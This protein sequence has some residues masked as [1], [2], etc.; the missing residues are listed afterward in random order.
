[1]G[2][3]AVVLLVGGITLVLLRGKRVPAP[4][5]VETSAAPADLHVVD[6]KQLYESYC[7]QCHG[8]RGTGDGPA[9]R[10]LYP[11]PRNFPEAK[12][13]VV[14]TVNHMP[15]D[16]DLLR[17]ITRGMPGSAMFSFAHLSESERHAL[18]GYV[19]QLAR[20]GLLEQFRAKLGEKADVAELE[21][22]IDQMLQ[23]GEACAVP[24]DLPASS[25]ESVAR[26]HKLY[27]SEACLDCHGETGKGDGV[28]DQRDAAGMP[29]RP[30]DFTRG[31]FKG[32]HEPAQLYARI[33]L[34]MSG[35]P[36]P[37]SPKLQ[38]AQVGD[39]INYILSL[40][41]PAARARVEHR[42]TRLLAKR[43][44]GTLPTDSA[45][46][47]WQVTVPAPILVSPL[48]WREYTEPNLHVAALHNGQTL[49]L[50][51]TWQDK[52]RDDR[53]VRPQDFEDMAAVQLY[54]GGREP[55]LGMGLA[56][57]AV[58][59]WLWRASWQA[60]A[61]KVADVDTTY[62]N[63]A[64]DLYPFERAGGGPRPHATE[65]Q[66]K[67][68]LTARAAGNLLSDPSRTFSGSSLQAKGFGTL[69]MRPAISQVVSASGSWKE[70]SWTVVLR[71]PLEVTSE[72][73]ISLAPGDALSIAFALWD[74]TARD[75]NGQ[76]LISIWHDLQ[77]E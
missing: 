24:A 32:G 21:Q 10:Y 22:D 36:M 26:G 74:G 14:T 40:S 11:R 1:L 30:R 44:S 69:T 43:T 52:T 59:T 53:P 64:V 45:D 20:T 37:E 77:L 63:M 58:D 76:K 39:L 3:L 49:A 42:R 25:A 57:K 28:K 5:P 31:F 41:D 35:T 2:S 18:V 7:A 65:R 4:Q 70:G 55:F 71:R 72:A 9:A 34:G 51:L 6:G 61:D 68:Y 46:D 27:R 16:Q 60:G 56:D 67:E 47:A 33:V 38:P 13:R 17:V 8:E 75:R 62:P 54:K 23:P 48:W 19:Q 50:R 29:I 15:S 12:F 73:G 66:A